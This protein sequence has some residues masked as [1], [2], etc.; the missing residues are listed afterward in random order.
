MTKDSGVSPDE[1]SPEG[2]GLFE[3]EEVEGEK[4]RAAK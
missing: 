1:G 4:M 2:V 3:E